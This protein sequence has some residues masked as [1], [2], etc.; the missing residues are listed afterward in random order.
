MYRSCPG[1]TQAGMGGAPAS[2]PCARPT[3]PSAPGPA[4][5]AAWAGRAGTRQPTP[6]AAC[7]GPAKAFP[8][9]RA[10]GSGVT[11]AQ[12]LLHAA[13]SAWG[14]ACE[15]EQALLYPG[16]QSEIVG[17][18]KPAACR[19]DRQQHPCTHPRTCR[20]HASMACGPSRLR[21]GPR[22][23]V[24]TPPAPAAAAAAATRACAACAAAAACS[25]A[26]CC[27]AATAAACAAARPAACAA[28]A[29]ETGG[30]G[31]RNPPPPP[32]PG[33][34]WQR[35]HNGSCQACRP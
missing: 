19:P 29:A 17:S 18:P 9:A 7:S 33:A 8:P 11:G 26:A 15:A 21:R 28:A 35:A 20:E 32:S 23:T 34:C 10:E 4:R 1:N 31:A 25:C 22:R 5:G 13:C 30:A 16:A 14:A 27:C 24:A 6:R 12:R 3:A 2:G